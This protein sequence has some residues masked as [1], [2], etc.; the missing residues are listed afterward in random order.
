MLCVGCFCATF[1]EH[2]HTQ[3]RVCVH[4]TEHILLLRSHQ[5]KPTTAATG[6]G[7]WPR[8][9][10]LLQMTLT[11]VEGAGRQRAAMSLAEP[12]HCWEHRG[13]GVSGG[14]VLHRPRPVL[15][16][17]RSAPHLG[18]DPGHDRDRG[19]GWGCLCSPPP[20][21]CLGSA[22]GSLRDFASC[23][24]AFC[25]HAGEICAYSECEFPGN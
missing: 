18:A 4:I 7:A 22:L 9:R 8:E 6:M 13:L 17:P 23:I 21:A 1:A 10:I 20:A 15:C 2:K 25:W 11:R 19:R 24:C 14:P 3:A 12:C 16:R 5:P